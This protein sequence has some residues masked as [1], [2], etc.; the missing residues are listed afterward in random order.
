MVTTYSYMRRL[1]FIV[2]L[3]ALLSCL[4]CSADGKPT[5]I[6]EGHYNYGIRALEIADGYLDFEVT[7]ESAFE[8]MELL[9]SEAAVLPTSE[10]GDVSHEKNSAV[11]HHVTMMSHDLMAAKFDKGSYDDLLEERNQLAE[12]VGK[13]KR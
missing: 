12:V 8:S 6:S 5:D 4:G 3:F 1:I 9:V 11:E 10:F 2:C 7:A 13:P